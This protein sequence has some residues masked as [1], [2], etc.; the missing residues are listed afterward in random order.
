MD[1]LTTQQGEIDMEIIEALG[2]RYWF[3]V[4]AGIVVGSLVTIA[5]SLLIISNKLPN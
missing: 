4:Y 2:G 1:S 5:Y 3:N